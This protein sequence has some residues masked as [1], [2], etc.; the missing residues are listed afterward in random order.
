MV[1]VAVG[2]TL[3]AKGAPDTAPTR[4]PEHAPSE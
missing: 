3:V 1:L 2:V 4:P